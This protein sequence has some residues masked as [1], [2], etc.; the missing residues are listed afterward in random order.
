LSCESNK[1]GEVRKHQ[2][3]EQEKGRTLVSTCHLKVKKEHLFSLGALSSTRKPNSSLS[4]VSNRNRQTTKGARFCF[5]NSERIKTATHPT[6]STNPRKQEQPG[7]RRTAIAPEFRSFHRPTEA[8]KE[9][10]HKHAGTNSLQQ[11]Q[12]G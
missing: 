9:E 4:S 7:N 2:L 10:L 1:R 5:P 11:Q 6:N 3:V 8:S 12:Q